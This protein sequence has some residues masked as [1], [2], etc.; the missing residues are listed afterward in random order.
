MVITALF[1]EQ[2]KLIGFSKVTRYLT[3]RKEYEE[4]LRQSEERYRSLVE[5]V[6]DYGIVMMDEKRRIT[7]WN[8]GARRINGYISDEIIGK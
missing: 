6:G 3:E 5:Q 2:N 4:N 1:N 7:S 8:A